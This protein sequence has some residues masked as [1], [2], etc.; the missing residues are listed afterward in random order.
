MGEN[1]NGIPQLTAVNFRSAASCRKDRAGTVRSPI[2]P[3]YPPSPLASHDE[4]QGDA[5]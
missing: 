5:A 1:V 2:L 4:R 3:F